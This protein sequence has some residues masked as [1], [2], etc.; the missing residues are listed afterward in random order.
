MFII[1]RE[2][3][4]IHIPK[5]SGTN[6][7]QVFHNSSNDIIDY[8]EVGKIKNLSISARNIFWEEI[9]ISDILE[10][11]FLQLSEVDYLTTKHSPLW[12]WQKSG[13][14]NDHKIITIVRNPYTRAV[15]MCKQVLRLF[16]VTANQNM[17]FVDFL[18]NSTIQSI[19]DRFPHSYKTQQVDY[20]KD[21]NDVVTIDRFYKM[22]TE[23]DQIAKDYNLTD[24]H[25]TKYNS[26]NYSKNYS[27]IY[28]DYLINWVQ[29]IYADDFEYFGYSI[30][31]FW[32]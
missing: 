26:G 16:G 17:S 28:N 2:D 27:E 1:N 29:K 14:W 4:Y 22:E 7:R 30:D 9:Y 32:M 23:L 19:I 5:T 20:I 18:S 13:D 10:H 3:M 11:P 8:D 31:P 6:L 12:V 24:I 21:I 25:T 15:S